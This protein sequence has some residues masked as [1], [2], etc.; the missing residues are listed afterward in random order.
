MVVAED[1]DRTGGGG[2]GAVHRLR[3]SEESR[4]VRHTA[5]GYY[6]NGAA[7]DLHNV[8]AWGHLG[9]GAPQPPPTQ[10]QGSF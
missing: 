4:T 9:P 3:S 10:P 8:V 5:I 6:R 1:S 7:T 2:G